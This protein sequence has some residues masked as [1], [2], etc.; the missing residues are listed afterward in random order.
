MSR[1]LQYSTT[2]ADPAPGDAARVAPR[3][4]SP[5]DCAA[6]LGVSEKTVYKMIQR[7]ELPASRL[8]GRRL[9]RIDLAD[10]DALMRPVPAARIR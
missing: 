8:A 3:Y 7:G 1:N 4:L 2:N 5:A 9:L 6:Y 10:V